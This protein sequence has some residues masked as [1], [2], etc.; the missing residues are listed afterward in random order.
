[1][2]NWATGSGTILFNEMPPQAK[3]DKFKEFF[4]GC[5]FDDEEKKVDFDFD[6]NYYA[7]DVFDMMDRMTEYTKD[8]WVDCESDSEGTCKCY[9]NYCGSGYIRDYANEYYE[10]DLPTDE[11][12]KTERVK[13]IVSTLARYL[14]EET[15]WFNDIVKNELKLT[16]KEINVLGL[17][18]YV[19]E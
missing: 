1:M 3:Q 12:F 10:S 6:G 15:V 11:V 2:S 9:W 5:Y 8:G 14:K 17:E 16:D 7:D 19:K 4:C 18:E 13:E